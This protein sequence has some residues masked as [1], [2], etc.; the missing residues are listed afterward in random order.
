L[1]LPR[2]G[3]NEKSSLELIC[4]N[5]TKGASHVRRHFPNKLPNKREFENYN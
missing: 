1:M 3:Q 2:P 4:K 5:K